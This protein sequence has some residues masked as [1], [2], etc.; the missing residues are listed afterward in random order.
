M[1]TF[2]RSADETWEADRLRERQAREWARFKAKSEPEPELDDLSLANGANGAGV[3]WSKPDL[4]ILQS[5]RLAAPELPLK[6]FGTYWS[7]WIRDQAEAKSCA[8]DYVA[9]GLLGGAGVL[10]GNAR[11][12]SPWNGWSEPP[13][14]WFAG[15]GYPSSGKSPGLDAIRELVSSIE[16]DQNADRKEDV[17]D[18]DTKSRL[19]KMRAELWEADCKK[20]LK[21]GATPPQR[22]LDAQEPPR[23]TR[24]RIVT[25][26][27]T[28]EKVARLVLENPKGLLVFRDELAGWIGALDKYG[29]AGGDRAFYLE[30]Y[31]GRAYAVDRMKESEPII[32]P[33]LSVGIMGGIQPDRL[34]TLV[35][36]GDDDGLAARFFY[37]WPERTPPKR[38]TRTIPTG[39]K[40]KL[41]LIHSLKANP[42]GS[43][44]P[45]QFTP[46]AANAIQQYRCQVANS[47]LE[48]TGLYLS[49]LGKMPGMAVRLATI[50]EHLYWVGEREDGAEPTSISETSAIAAIAFLDSYAIPMARRCFGEAILPQVDKDARTIARWIKAHP[51]TKTINSRKLRQARVLSSK[52][53][54]AAAYDAALAELRAAC[55]IR[56]I[57]SRDGDGDGR[58]RKDWQINERLA[59]EV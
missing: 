3:E 41:A 5:Q 14:L 35:F 15:V 58:Q 43:V 8:P 20:A 17:A 51:D 40:A 32:V 10:L 49:W 52:D 28:V 34:N 16:A 4:T 6:V 31:G 57:P 27:P 37:V 33:A 42:D 9:G 24:K 54:T 53:A 13:L 30:S 11:W 56:P 38:P 2:G 1:S 59:K 44:I 29:G 55:W 47:E 25:N 22:P 46:A 39:A 7:G 12:G 50:L 45:L 36:S 26:D 18:W 21:A 23:P 19:A 48:A